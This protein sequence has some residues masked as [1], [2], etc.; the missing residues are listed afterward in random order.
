MGCPVGAVGVAVT[1]GVAEEPPQGST[2]DQGSVM[3][4]GFAQ[5]ARA[6]RAKVKIC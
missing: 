4:A 2:V 3:M 1:T 5:T 6:K